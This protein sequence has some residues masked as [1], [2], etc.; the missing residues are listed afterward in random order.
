MHPP[1][2]PRPPR[3]LC[4]EWLFWDPETIDRYP[5]ICGS[6]GADEAT[7]GATVPVVIDATPVVSARLRSRITADLLVYLVGVATGLVCIA[8]TALWIGVWSLSS[9]L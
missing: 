2:P 7:G 1:R 4:D 5:Q 8:L 3:P 6:P 9:Q